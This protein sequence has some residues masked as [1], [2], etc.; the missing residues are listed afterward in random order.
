MQRSVSE[1]ESLCGT[2][3][4]IQSQQ[5]F[6]VFL[7]SKENQARVFPFREVRSKNT[8]AVLYS[9]PAEWPQENVQALFHHADFSATF[10]VEMYCFLQSLY[11]LSVWPL[12]ATIFY[13][14]LQ[15]S[16]AAGTIYFTNTSKRIG[17]F[18]QRQRKPIKPPFF[19]FH[20]YIPV[21][22]T[23]V[24]SFLFSPFVT[25][26]TAVWPFGEITHC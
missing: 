9:Q 23:P 24:R 8:S 1:L 15:R 22:C 18:F 13:H 7:A 14:Q 25:Y 17:Y 12:V 19:F 21:S 4:K 20:I 5:G 16:L 6:F 2:V 10:C 3:S 26:C 11:P